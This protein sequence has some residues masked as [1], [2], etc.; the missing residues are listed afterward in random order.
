M[1]QVERAQMSH[2][3]QYHER[4]LERDSME[5]VIHQITQ[6]PI[7][8]DEDRVIDIEVRL[9]T[10]GPQEAIQGNHEQENPIAQE[11]EH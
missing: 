8:Q 11:T 5:Q 9:E 3:T 7:A 2:E 6:I 4:A 10:D 1:H